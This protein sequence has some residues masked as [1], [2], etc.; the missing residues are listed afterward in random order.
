MATASLGSYSSELVK[1]L[2]DLR[3]QREEVQRSILRDEEER[4]RIQKVR[5]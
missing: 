5:C 2:E 1:A 3:E 4:A